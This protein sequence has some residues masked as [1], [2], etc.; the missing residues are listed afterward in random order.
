[1]RISRLRDLAR[2]IAVTFVGLSCSPG[3]NAQTIPSPYRFLEHTHDA[4][5]MFGVVQEN[6]GALGI[7]PGGDRSSA[8]ATQS[9]FEDPSRWSSLVI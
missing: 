4:G 8:D 7:G 6:R 9:N 1:M 2:I 3:A 5:V